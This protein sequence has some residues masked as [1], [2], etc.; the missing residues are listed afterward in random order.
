MGYLLCFMITHTLLVEYH[1]HEREDG[2]TSEDS[3]VM[4]QTRVWKTEYKCM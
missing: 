3:V 1:A 4:R 2:K